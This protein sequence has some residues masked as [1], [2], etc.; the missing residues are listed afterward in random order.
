M[1]DDAQV[2]REKAAQLGSTVVE[3]AK[4]SKQYIEVARLISS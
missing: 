1:Q 3:V 2:A 4:D